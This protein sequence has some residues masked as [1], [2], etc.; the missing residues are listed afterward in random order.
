LPIVEA[1]WLLPTEKTRI[2][3]FL[4]EKSAGWASAAAAGKARASDAAM[5]DASLILNSPFRSGI[6][7]GVSFSSG[8][9]RVARAV[10]APTPSRCQAL[11]AIRQVAS[12][13]AKV[14]MVLLGHGNLT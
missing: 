9:G 6:P 12:C 2:P 8:A 10:S 13:E 14:V 5:I 7:V 1:E 11:E 4:A 3:S